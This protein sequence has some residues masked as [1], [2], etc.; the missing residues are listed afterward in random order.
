MQSN[1][2]AF[3]D[4]ER[5]V[6]AV[7]KAVYDLSRSSSNGCL[8]E[9]VA[10]RTQ[11]SESEVSE[12]LNRL[13]LTERLISTPTFNSGYVMTDKGLDRLRSYTRE[14]NQS[15][16]SPSQTFILNNSAPVGFQQFGNN[17]IADN[18][19]QNFGANLAETLQI[20]GSLQQAIT[21]LPHDDQNIATESLVVIEEET[22]TPTNRERL[23]NALFALWRVGKDVITFANA[24]TALAQRF[25]IHLPQ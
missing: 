1:D 24:V 14:F 20:I 7:L 22:K 2:Q 3:M 13:Q 15:P 11:L 6:Y 8:K 16:Q 19:N 23:E 12:I 17:N 5:K 10:D 21:T 18:I 4:D 9:A 25:N